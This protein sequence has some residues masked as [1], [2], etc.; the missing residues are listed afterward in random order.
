MQS[1]VY[2]R[3]NVTGL[4]S[5]LERGQFFLVF[6]ASDVHACMH[7]NMHVFVQLYT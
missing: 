2:G 6:L 3:G 7:K 1:S 4:T 5:I